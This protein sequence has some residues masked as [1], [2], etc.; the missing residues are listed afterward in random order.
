MGKTTK[1]SKAKKKK[2]P[3]KKADQPQDD[4]PVAEQD[5]RV[6][7]EHDDVVDDAA[8]AADESLADESLADESPASESPAGESDA[9]ESRADSHADPDSDDP[10]P[11]SG[12]DVTAPS[13]VEAILFSTDVPIAPSKIAQILG[14]GDAKDVL[15]HVD[16]LNEKYESGGASF[17]VRR[18][19]KGLQ[20]LTLPE[21]NHWIKQLHKTRADSRLSAAAL[22]TLAIVAYKQ[23]IMRADVESIRGVAVGDMLVRLRDVNLVKIVGRAEEIGRPL[24]Y[25]TTPRFLEVFGLNSLKDLPKIEEEGGKPRLRPIAE[26]VDEDPDADPGDPESSAPDVETAGKINDEGATADSASVDSETADLNE[27]DA[28]ITE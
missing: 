2:S 12:V 14:T 11:A 7:D 5:V 10:R 1:A 28:E 26:E 13:V 25:G 16:A 22:E 19:A 4:Q 17:R 23:P 8:E 3:R 24:L 18:I 20:L 15:R 9:G 6:E 21:Y 27:A